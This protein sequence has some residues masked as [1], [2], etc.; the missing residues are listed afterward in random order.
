[1]YKFTYDA[2]VISTFN[3]QNGPLSGGMSLTISGSN[4]GPG[5]LSQSAYIG[6]TLCARTDWRTDSSV[7]CTMSPG[8]A[9]GKGVYITVSGMMGTKEEVFSFDAPILSFMQ[10]YNMPTTAGGQVTVEGTNFGAYDFTPSV[11][12]ESTMCS[13]TSWTSVTSTVCVSDYGTGALPAQGCPHTRHRSGPL[14]APAEARRWKRSSRRRV[15]P[16]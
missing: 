11:R 12:I 5:G 14:V 6:D 16:E 2:P 10:L 8:A 13:T 7:I 15:A 9:V 1:M 3:V 4:F